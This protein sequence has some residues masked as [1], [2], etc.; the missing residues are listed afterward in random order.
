MVATHLP[1][2][3]A[4]I[5]EPMPAQT[6]ISPKTY[7]QASE[8]LTKKV[9]NVAMAVIASVPAS[10]IGL[11]TQYISDTTAAAARPNASFTQT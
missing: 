6:K 8:R 9:L 5:T 4:M 3:S 7:S 2:F 10:Q 1:N 11:S